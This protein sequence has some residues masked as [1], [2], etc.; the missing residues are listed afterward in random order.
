MATTICMIGED[1]PEK[2]AAVDSLAQELGRR[3]YKVGVIRPEPELAAPRPKAL[4]RVADGRMELSRPLDRPMELEEITGRYLDDLDVV[5]SEAHPDAK[6]PKVAY[7]AEG[8][9][10]G[11]AEDPG[12]VAVVGGGDEPGKAGR[13]APDDIAGLADLLEPRL[14]PPARPAK[15]RILIDG[16]R[17]PAKRFIQDIVAGTLGSLIG[18]LKGGDRPGPMT[19]FIE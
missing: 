3:G 2:R 16:R 9:T 10:P 8:S 1:R 12:L 17:V 11:L 4:L 15:V 18:S 6:R 7:A 14:G 13:F 5:L 19:I